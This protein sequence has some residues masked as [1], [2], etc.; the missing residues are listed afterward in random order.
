[1]FLIFFQNHYKYNHQ[2]NKVMRNSVKLPHFIYD[3]LKEFD[4]IYILINAQKNKTSHLNLNSNKLNYVQE[5]LNT[6]VAEYMPYDLERYSELEPSINYT[7]DHKKL[8][9]MIQAIHQHKKRFNYLVSSISRRKFDQIYKIYAKEDQDVLYYITDGT[10]TNEDANILSEIEYP[11]EMFIDFDCFPINI[12]L[13]PMLNWE[14]FEDDSKHSLASE[15]HEPV[16]KQEKFLPELV[17][18]KEEEEID[19]GTLRL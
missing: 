14:E 12:R 13:P 7:D 10:I 8:I 5:K 6:K 4:T 18:R 15:A 9:G 11:Y 17:E 3:E 2:N 19:F 1:M 16:E